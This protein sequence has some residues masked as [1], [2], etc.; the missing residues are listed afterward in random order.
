[1]GLAA[2][3]AL[4]CNVVEPE[5]VLDHSYSHCPL[6][7]PTHYLTMSMFSL[8]L[9]GSHDNVVAKFP[10]PPWLH[11]CRTFYFDVGSNRGV[12]VRKLFQ[13]QFYPKAAVHPLFAAAFGEQRQMSSNE[14][15]ICAIGFEPNPI[16]R[17]RLNCI[18]HDL[19][20]R[21]W[22]VHF[23]RAGAWMRDTWASFQH[24][25][26]GGLEVGYHMQEVVNSISNGANARTPMLD[27]TR[28]VAA[29]PG[30]IALMKMDIEGAEWAVLEK[31]VSLG[32]LC[33]HKVERLILE[34]HPLNTRW[35][36]S[37][38]RR[39]AMANVTENVRQ[40]AHKARAQGRPCRE[41]SIVDLDDL[42]YQA[43]GYVGEPG[44][45]L[46]RDAGQGQTVC[47]DESLL[48]KDENAKI[49]R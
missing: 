10:A 34:P 21:G 11:R 43:E 18:Q 5:N 16:H 44:I 14:S 39:S 4:P 45:K 38:E 30:S 3:A 24:P 1:M 12:Q 20:S 25:Q 9:V 41:T 32:L 40:Y 27:L 8:G 2:R 42:T 49:I 17:L 19:M 26:R 22:W 29:L 37:S 48:G 36:S 35:R 47:N 23:Y 33:A 6:S 28:L 15:G 31:M 13:P 46:H 7:M